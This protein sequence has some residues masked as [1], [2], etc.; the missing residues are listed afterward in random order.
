MKGLTKKII[1]TVMIMALLVSNTA[2][3]AS[4]TAG[5]MTLSIVDGKSTLTVGEAQ[6]PLTQRLDTRDGAID[7]E[8]GTVY[9]ILVSGNLYFYNYALQKNENTVRLIKIGAASELEISES[10]SSV[11]VGY[12]NSAG[13]SCK[14]LTMA[15]IKEKLGI[16]E[17]TTVIP[18]IPGNQNTPTTPENQTTPTN[19][20][21]QTTSVTQTTPTNT[22]TQTT[23]VTQTTQT[24]AKNGVSKVKGRV[25]YTVTKNGKTKSYQMPMSHPD[26][27][28][29]DKNRTIW[30]KGRKGCLYVWNYDLQKSQ[31]TIKM[32]KVTSKKCTGLVFN[33]KGKVVGYYMAGS[34]K[35]KNIWSK[36]KIKKAIKK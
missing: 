1:A 3:A 8:T 29:I 2:L 15:E 26:R 35:T 5:G 28:G 14:L 27:Y 36:Q 13:V 6:V 32:V 16:K 7:P 24:K 25:V 20:S 23:S 9:L 11:L 34:G 17:E 10:N 4:F 19:T 31:K 21:T 22:S 12:K 18:T 30:I 33:K